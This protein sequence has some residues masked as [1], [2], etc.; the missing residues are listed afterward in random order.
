MKR[1]WGRLGRGLGRGLGAPFRAMGRQF[2]QGAVESAETQ[3]RARLDPSPEPPAKGATMPGVLGHNRWTNLVGIVT[4]IYQ[5]LKVVVPLLQGQ[6]PEVSAQD[7]P[8]TVLGIGMLAAKDRDVTGG[9]R[10]Q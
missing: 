3:L 2:A 5:V 1:F 10:A 6:P 9:R 7:I 8:T 4:L